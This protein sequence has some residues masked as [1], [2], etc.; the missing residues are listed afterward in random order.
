[1]EIGPI[2]RAMLQSRVRVA[3][4]VVEVAVTLA[5]V[6]N[7]L[8][9]IASQRARI[10]RPTGIDEAHLIAVTLRPWTRDL[11]EYEARLQV[12][13]RDLAALR[14][15]PGVRDATIISTRPLQ[16]GGSSFQVRPMGAD[17][18]RW[19]RSPVYGADPH[20]FDTLGLEIVAGRGFTDADMPTGPGIPAS[21]VVVTQDLADAL[22]PDGDALGQIVDSGDPDRPG[23]IVGIVSPMFTPYGG[24][25]MES[26]ITF[27]PMK[28]SS[29]GY[30]LYLVRTRP[31]DFDDVFSRLDE[32]LLKVYPD[33][34]VKVTSMLDVKAGG[35]SQN[36]ILARILWVIVWL[37]L[38]VTAL[39]IFGM[40]SFSVAQRTKQIG[41]RRALGATRSAVLRH[42]LVES[43]LVTVMGIVIGLPAAYGLNVALVNA[44][45]GARLDGTLVAAAVLGL[46]LL[47]LAA[48][49]FPARRASL[50]PPALATQT[51]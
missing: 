51:V 24:G 8:T 11:T 40:A 42:F 47:G 49:A 18:S 26:R 9:M 5:I 29:A 19:V 28:P 43:S 30:M 45:G 46:W 37:L 20:V 48:T 50:I 14:A 35:I 6:L 13:D 38:F 21:N 32:A 31:G 41:T 1:M 4:L 2:L 22:F 16:G 34:T 39:G 17:D 10:T 33:R 15:L 25:P 44:V 3:L 23:T 36:L 7:C 27:Y 12:V